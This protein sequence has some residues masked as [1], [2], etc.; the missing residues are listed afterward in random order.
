MLRKLLSTATFVLFAVSFAFAQSGSVTGVVTDASTGETLPGVNIV[1]QELQQGTPTGANGEFTLDDVPAGT[2]TLTASFVGFKEYSQQIQVGSDE[3]ELQIK[4]E[5]AVTGLDDVVVTAF[6]I[7]REKKAVGYG[8]SEISGED[9]QR[10]TNTDISRALSGKLPGVNISS[11]GGVSGSGSDINIRGF[12]SISGSNNPLIVVDG[13]K[14]DGGNNTTSDWFDGGGQQTNPSRLLDIDPSNVADV[15]VLKGLSATVLYGEEG[16]NGV[17]L[18]TTNSGSFDEGGDS[19]FEVTINQ[20]VYAKQI[21][22]RPDYQNKYGGG[23]DQNFGWF[24]SNWGPRFSATDSTLFGDNFRGYAD[25]GTVLIEH[26]LVQ[27]DAQAEA[28]PEYKDKDYR[29]EAKPDPME[30]FFRTGLTSTTSF[31]VRGGNEVAR[32]N[33]NYGRT[34]EEGFTPNNNVTRN[35][36]SAGLNYKISDKL[37]SQTSFNLSLTDVKTPPIS[38]GSG[39]GSYSTASVFGD[40]FYTPRSID[41][42]AFPYQNPATN[43]SAYYRS[44]NDIPNPRWTANE[45]QY[46]NGTNRVFGKTELNYEVMEGLQVVYRLGYDSYTETQEFKQNPGITADADPTFIDGFY[47]TVNIDKSSWD[48]YLNVLLDYQLTEAISLNGTLGAQYNVESYQ[49]HGVES[50]NMLIYDLFEHPN[51]TS[52]S[53]NNTFGGQYQYE[54][55]TQTAGVFANLIFGYEDWAYLT[56]SGRNDWFS[57][58]E[59]E[60]NSLFYPSAKLSYIVS[61]HLDI[62][63]DVL[64]F[65]KVFGGIGTSAGSPDPYS[66]RSV[67]SSNARDFFDSSGNVITTNATSDFLGNP[68]LKPEL[69]KEYEVGID[70]RFLNGRIGLTAQ[71]YLKTTKDLITQAPI[72]PATGY[73]STNINIGEVENK[74]LEIS[75][76]GT[77]VQGEFQWNIN[78]NWAT[79]ISEVTELGGG[80]DRINVAGFTD[81]GNFAVPGEPFLVMMGST[82]ERVTEEMKKNQSEFSDVEVGTPIVGS[83]GNYLVNDSELNVIGNPNPDWTSSITNTLNYK[84]LSFSFQVDYQQGGDMFSTWISTL[85]ARGLTTDTGIDRNNTFIL[86]GVNQNGEKN[87]TMISPSGVFFDNF[88]FGSDELRVYDMTHVRLANVSLTYDLPVSLISNTPFKGISLSVTGDNLWMHAFNVPEGSGFDPNVNSIGGNSR[89]FEYLTGPAARTFGGKVTIQL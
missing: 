64:T 59:P 89:G 36:F 33:V 80:L 67:L 63:G 22:S 18:I 17:I 32:V 37:S 15:S 49:Q 26:P 4:L 75:L 7:K 78:A 77:P 48:H 53:T 68:D 13:V 38:S 88:G 70:T 55:K 56:L 11:A 5:S 40:V 21:S 57:T 86:P 39:S 9:L 35:N 46:L 24:F 42:F 2:Y 87:S 51:F 28:F 27:N 62:T 41:M 69:H 54:Q 10:Q 61:D 43:G 47:Q 52:H 71:A 1:I 29:Y 19:G 8:V 58:L 12:S 76:N 31:N 23:F 72:D 73:T 6:G 20:S 14:F 3:L 44:G 45:V 25:D 60:H 74:G 79:N 83:S 34:G 50:Q 85:L 82:I 81:R 16:R 66:T 65:L 30:S 84:N